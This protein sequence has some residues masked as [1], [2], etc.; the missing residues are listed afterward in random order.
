M[1]AFPFLY[2][3]HFLSRCFLSVKCCKSITKWLGNQL[4]YGALMRMIIESY[5]IGIISCMLNLRWIYL[6]NE[7]TDNWSK[8]NTF[9][10]LVVL[11]LYLLFPLLGIC[12]IKKNQNKWNNK[13]V[14]KRFGEL[15]VGFHIESNSMVIYWAMDFF[16]RILLAFSLV[17]YRSHLWL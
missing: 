16:R 6:S 10:T 13:K 11:P 17:F 7:E 12:L 4:Y 14:R 3:Y 9:V 5:V 2:T 8:A 1:A 15:L